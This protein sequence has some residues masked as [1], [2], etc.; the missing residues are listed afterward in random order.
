MKWRVSCYSRGGDVQFGADGCFSYRHLRSAGDGPIS[1]DPTYFISKEKVDAT[2]WRMEKAKG[3]PPAKYKP[4]IPE[5]AIDACK[6]SW[7]AADEKKQKA[8]PKR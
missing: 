1:Y 2:A 7:D 8:D 4:S 5:E 6:E 3:R